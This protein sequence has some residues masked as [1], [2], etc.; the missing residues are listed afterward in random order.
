MDQNQTFPAA[1]TPAQAPSGQPQTNEQPRD[2]YQRLIGEI[3]K[4]QIVILGPDIAIAKARTVQGIKVSDDGTVTEMTGD[5]NKII[6][7]LIDVYV[8]LSGLIIKKTME[9]LLS[10][11]PNIRIP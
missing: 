11:Y 6:Q 1:P 3:I 8:A 7:S 2:N 5:P 4:K 9:P 10:K